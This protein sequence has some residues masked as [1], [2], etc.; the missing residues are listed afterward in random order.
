MATVNKISLQSCSY[1]NAVHQKSEAI[2]NSQSM[3]SLFSKGR[4]SLH[5]LPAVNAGFIVVGLKFHGW[6]L[7]HSQSDTDSITA[8]IILHILSAYIRQR[9]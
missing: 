6:L 9:S 3:M 1:S 4:H 7:H 2:Y 8:S 5:L